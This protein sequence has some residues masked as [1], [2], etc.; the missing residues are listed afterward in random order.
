MAKKLRV[1]KVYTTLSHMGW[2]V[3]YITDTAKINLNAEH[4][5]ILTRNMNVTH[6][7]IDI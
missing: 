5:G 6:F 3:L 2:L 1:K 7:L 4:G